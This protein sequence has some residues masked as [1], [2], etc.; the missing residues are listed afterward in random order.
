LIATLATI[1]NLSSCAAHDR[2]ARDAVQIHPLKPGL[3]SDP[4]R[5]VHKARGKAQKSA[6]AP[7]FRKEALQARSLPSA[8]STTASGVIPKCL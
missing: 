3:L 1:V 4:R 2:M 5:E 8:A 7:P 6:W